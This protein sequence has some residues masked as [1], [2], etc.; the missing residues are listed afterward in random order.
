MQLVVLTELGG[1]ISSL[2]LIIFYTFVVK[3]VRGNINIKE[4]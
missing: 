3:T 1:I 2:E 4:K